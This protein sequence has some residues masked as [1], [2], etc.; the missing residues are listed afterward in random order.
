MYLIKHLQD[1]SHK[2]HHRCVLN[3]L[4]NMNNTE[5]VNDHDIVF[6]LDKTKANNCCHFNLSLTVLSDNV[7]VCG[8]PGTNKEI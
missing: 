8:T 6:Q 4:P 7:C 5:G 2:M 1:I 3:R